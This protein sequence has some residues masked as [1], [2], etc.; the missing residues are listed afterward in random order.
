MYNNTGLT[1]GEVDELTQSTH[2]WTSTQIYKFPT[3]KSSSGSNPVAALNLDETT[4]IYGQTQYGGTVGYGTVFK[5][6]PQKDGSWALQTLHSF[7][8]AQGKGP[9]L[10]PVMD[11]SGNIFGV[12]RSGGPYGFGTIYKLAPPAAGKAAWDYQ[13]IYGGAEGHLN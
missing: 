4:A 13:S 9:R 7:T 3:N 12:T 6:I 10:N 1:N 11:S 8:G 5:L 2:G